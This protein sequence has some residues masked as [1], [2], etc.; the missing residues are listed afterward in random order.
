MTVV[1]DLQGCAG[2]VTAQIDPD[3]VGTGMPLDVGERLLRDA[4]ER[5]AGRLIEPIAKDDGLEFGLDPGADPE[6]VSKRKSE[7]SSFTIVRSAS[8][9]RA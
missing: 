7:R 2:P 1:L 6:I 3:V 5:D 9:D 8:C 4:V